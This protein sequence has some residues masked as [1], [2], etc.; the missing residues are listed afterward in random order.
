MKEFNYKLKEG[1][2]Y[3]LN[4]ELETATFICIKSPTAKNLQ[5]LAPLKSEVMKAIQWAQ[6]QATEET[7]VIEVGDGEG[8]EISP[9]IIMATLEVADNVDILKV[10][11]C[12]EFMITKGLGQVE[13]EV[14]FSKPKYDELSIPDVYGITGAFIANFIMPS[15]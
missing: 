8:S 4:G 15:L 12:V 5:E 14:K 13:G 3:A 7:E 9:E 2:E 1:F 10:L 11:G 6:S